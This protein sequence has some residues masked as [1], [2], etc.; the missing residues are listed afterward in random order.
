MDYYGTASNLSFAFGP[1]VAAGILTGGSLNSL[2]RRAADFLGGITGHTPTVENFTLVFI[3]GGFFALIAVLTT[4]T[5]RGRRASSDAPKRS[6]RSPAEWFTPPAL[7]PASMAFVQTWGFAAIITSI[8]LL[9]EARGMDDAERYFYFFYAGTILLSRILL[10][11]CRTDTGGGGRSCGG[12]R[13]S[14]LPCS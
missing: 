8:P 5:M 10:A 13:R 11:A 3:A 2:N 4:L 6:L 1:L 9:T 12:W 14:R 7:L